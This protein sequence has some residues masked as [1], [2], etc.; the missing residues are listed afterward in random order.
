MNIRSILHMRK[1]VPLAAAGLMLVAAAPA[2]AHHSFAMF[3]DEAQ[4]VTGVL[5]EFHFTNPHTFILLE[6]VDDEGNVTLWNLEGTNPS[7]LVRQGW[8]PDSLKAGDELIVT[9]N[10]LRSGAPG[11]SWSPAS[12]TFLD[13]SPVVA[14]N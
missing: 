9:I 2:A 1:G 3:S 12:A 7:N 10:P 13:G 8:R 11:G 14:R 4:Q 6:V 5:R